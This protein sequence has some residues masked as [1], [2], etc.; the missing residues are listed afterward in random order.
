MCYV[1]SICLRFGRGSASLAPLAARSIAHQTKP[2]QPK[3]NQSKPEPTKT[4]TRR[5]C[6]RQRRHHQVRGRVRCRSRQTRFCLPQLEAP[7]QWSHLM[8][9]EHGQTQRSVLLMLRLDSTVDAWHSA[10]VCVAT[11]VEGCWK[12]HGAPSGPD[13]EIGSTCGVM[14]GSMKHMHIGHSGS[15]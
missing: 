5:T 3:R 6:S 11:S 15:C 8:R 14:S 7:G 1:H 13:C 4:I 10:I 12:G 9:V 2:N